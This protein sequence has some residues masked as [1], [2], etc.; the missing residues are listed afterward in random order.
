M[1]D[2]GIMMKDTKKRVWRLSLKSL[3]EWIIPE[4]TEMEHFA[5]VLASLFWQV[6][7]V[8]GPCCS[9]IGRPLR[10][11]NLKGTSLY[12][13]KEE[14]GKTFKCWIEG[15]KKKESEKGRS[16]N[17]AKLIIAV[18]VPLRQES[19]FLSTHEPHIHGEECCLY[20]FVCLLNCNMHHVVFSNIHLE[21]QEFLSFLSIHLEAC[22]L[23]Q[24][25]PIPLPRP[26]IWF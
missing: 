26:L 9:G 10:L 15:G 14:I 1:V 23:V 13:N 5:S 4:G 17:E 16:I 11:S 25:V 3:V 22:W 24:S 21:Y 7:G 12:G 20:T 6:K 8:D 18:S 19:H 2:N